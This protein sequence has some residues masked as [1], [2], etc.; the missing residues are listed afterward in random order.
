MRETLL[1]D[2]Y[3]EMPAVLQKILAAYP[4]AKL[5]QESRGDADYFPVIIELG[6]LDERTWFEWSINN[7]ILPYCCG[8]VLL[9]MAPPEWVKLVI[10]AY[11]YKEAAKKLAG[12]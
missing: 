4:T 3:A 1:F 7:N 8:M 2:N 9:T 11:R 5:I 10:E 6:D 12:G